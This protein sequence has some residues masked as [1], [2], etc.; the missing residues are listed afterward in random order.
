MTWEQYLVATAKLSNTFGETRYSKKNIEEGFRYWKGQDNAVL[1]EYV[2]KAIMLA[3]PFDLVTLG[4][5]LMPKKEPIY[6]RHEAAQYD[7]DY[8]NR[9]KAEHGAE[10]LWDLVLKFKGVDENKGDT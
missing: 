6:Y 9:L 1:L 7:S 2:G 8:L 5:S 3:K 10:T 4:K